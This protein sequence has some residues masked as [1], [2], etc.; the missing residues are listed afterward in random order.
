MNSKSVLC[1][2]ATLML[3][4]QVFAQVPFFNVDIGN[5]VVFPTPTS[6]YSAATSQAGFW[7]GRNA[8]APNGAL[9][10]I[11]ESCPA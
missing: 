3:C 11:N 8:G 5:N 4:G 1:L 9:I 10:D 2:A 7:N 6:I